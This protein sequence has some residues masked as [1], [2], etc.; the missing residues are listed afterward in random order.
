[1]HLQYEIVRLKT[2]GQSLYSTDSQYK[3]CIST[4]ELSEA[5]WQV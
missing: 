1:M 2:I 3:D 4:A 5:F